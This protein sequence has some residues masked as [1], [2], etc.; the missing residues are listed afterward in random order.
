[1]CDV[2]YLGP[3]LSNVFD[4][5]S[6]I[7]QLATPTPGKSGGVLVTSESVMYADNSRWAIYYEYIEL[8]SN[9]GCRLVETFQ[10]TIYRG[11]RLRLSHD[12]RGECLS[13]T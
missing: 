11:T 5:A 7:P 9:L 8:W 2:L 10:S 1:V 12:W 3:G 4:D 6:H 13:H